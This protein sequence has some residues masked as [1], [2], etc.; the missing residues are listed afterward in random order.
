MDVGRVVLRFAGRTGVRDRISLADRLTLPDAER[1]EMRKGGLVAV[2]GHDRDRQPVRRDLTGERD[3]PG[4]RRANRRCAR[5]RDV[6]AAMLARGVLVVLYGESAQNRTVGGPR[7]PPGRFG[8][9]SE[10]PCGDR[11]DADRPSRCP[12]SEHGATVA[13]VRPGGNAIDGLVT[14]SRGR[15]RCG[16]RRSAL[17]RPRRQRDA[18]LRPPPARTLRTALGRPPAPRAGSPPARARA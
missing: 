10:R 11:T 6:D 1:A 2:R 9:Q 12:T 8:A 7:P 18:T 16:T 13:R 14:E 5:E 4:G 3:L 17:Q 15:A